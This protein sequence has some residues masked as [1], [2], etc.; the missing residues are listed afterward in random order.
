MDKIYYFYKTT[1]L[2]NGKYY[3]GSG[4]SIKPYFGS[5]VNIIRAVKKYG[6]G[7]FKTDRLRFFETRED[8]YL[9]EDRFL[10]LYKISGDKNC[11]NIKNSS[12]GGD[13]FTNNPNKEMIR[14]HYRESRINQMKDPE[15]RALCNAFRNLTEDELIERTKV[16]SDAAKGSKNG[17]YKYDQKVGQYDQEGNLIKIWDDVSTIG[18]EPSY[19][20]KYVLMCCK[21]NLKTHAR[22]IWKFLEN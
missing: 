9:F 12:L 16:W 14:E 15:R 4:S 18:R 8:A 21:G 5:G 2:I 6:I 3:Y 19:T 20:H 13:S 22:F 11:Y 10:K 1:N 7:N 17:R